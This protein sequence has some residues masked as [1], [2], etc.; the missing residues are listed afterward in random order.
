MWNLTFHS[1]FFISCAVQGIGIALP[2]SQTS[3]QVMA[4]A[5]GLIIQQT[6]WYRV[7]GLECLPERVV[8][9][10]SAGGVAAVCLSG[11]V[12]D[13]IL[14]GGSW[15]VSGVSELVV[16]AGVCV[17]CWTS[18]ADSAVGVSSRGASRFPRVGGAGVTLGALVFSGSTTLPVMPLPP[19]SRGGD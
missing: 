5:V 7:E 3:I 10:V 9:L 18:G 8:V 13:G 1:H 19:N 4:L 12:A 6:S 15:L 17:F 2:R 16:L 14:A 11:P